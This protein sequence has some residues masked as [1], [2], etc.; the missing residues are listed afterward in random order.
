MFLSGTSFVIEL[1]FE[2]SQALLEDMVSKCPN[3]DRNPFQR[4]VENEKREKKRLMMMITM[5]NGVIER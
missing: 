4:F 5:K 3:S 1:R 2:R